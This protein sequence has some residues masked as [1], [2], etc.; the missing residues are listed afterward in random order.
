MRLEQSR[1]FSQSDRGDRVIWCNRS[2]DTDRAIT[3]AI[4]S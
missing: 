3:E 1:S 2:I 4:E